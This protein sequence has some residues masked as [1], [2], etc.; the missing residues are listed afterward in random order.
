MLGRPANF[1]WFLTCAYILPKLVKSI[2]VQL[3]SSSGQSAE[4]AVFLESTSKGSTS[5]KIADPLLSQGHELGRL[6]SAGRVANEQAMKGGPAGLMAG[7]LQVI[8]F[9]WLR[10]TMNVQYYTGRG[11]FTTVK[12]LWKEGGPARF[13]QGL[14]WA[15]LQA[16]LSRFGDAFANSWSLSLVSAL[17]PSS[18]PFVGTA[19]GVTLSSAWRVL[20]VPIDTIKTASQVHGDA[21]SSVLMGKV[22]EDGILQLWSGSFASFAANWAQN[23]PWWVTLNTV[24]A[25]WPAPSDPVWALLRHGITGMMA[26]IVADCIP[27]P[28]RVLKT[29]RQV[30]PDTAVGYMD[31]CRSVIK[32]DG[33]HGLLFRGLTTRVLTN[34]LQ[35]SFFS[36]AWRIFGAVH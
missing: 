33:L 20:L 15:V 32:T 3:W 11:F 10:T 5:E 12:E 7:L 1:L 31:I 19:L 4:D 16:P 24:E 18:P 14:H 8:L 23:F 26:S 13:Y 35:G 17:M 36:I 22:K 30:S 9:M 28:L 29:V 6:S 25:L 2:H 21:A 34:V 27:N